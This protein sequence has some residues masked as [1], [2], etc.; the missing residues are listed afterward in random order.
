MPFRFEGVYHHRTGGSCA[1]NTAAMDA[2]RRVN[3]GKPTNSPR[4]GEAGIDLDRETQQLEDES[5]EKFVKAFDVLLN[6]LEEKRV[7]ALR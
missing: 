5:V 2:A 7:A 6:T 3:K 4:V 1:K